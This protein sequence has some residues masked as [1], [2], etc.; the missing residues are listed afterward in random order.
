M[1]FTAYDPATSRGRVRLLCRDTT[2]PGHLY[3]DAEIDAFLALAEDNVLLAGAM[4]LENV[5]SN[6]VLVQKRIRLLDLQT[7]GPAEATALLKLAATLRQQAA[8]FADDI[9]W[10]ELV[11]D[12][13]T[14][15]Q[16]L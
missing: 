13:D 6:E 5:A 3:E 7:D 10:V 4:A 1:T 14:Y 15:M 16:R 11:Y 9:D 12:H 8:D 2:T